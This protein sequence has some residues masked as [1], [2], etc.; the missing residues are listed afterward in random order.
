MM[1]P[2]QGFDLS[3]SI[4]I[5]TSSLRER[6]IRGNFNSIALIFKWGLNN[7]ER[8]NGFSQIPKNYNAFLAKAIL[9]GVL[10]KWDKSRFY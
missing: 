5:I 4:F 10:R 2:F 3:L 1:S 6:F 9:F 7:Q 8:K